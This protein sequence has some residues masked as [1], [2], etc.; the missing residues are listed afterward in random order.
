MSAESKWNSCCICTTGPRPGGIVAA[1]PAARN[2][3]S[4]APMEDAELIVHVGF[5]ED[6]AALLRNDQPTSTFT[7]QLPTSVKLLSIVPA[8]AEKR[9]SHSRQYSTEP[10]V[11][12]SAPGWIVVD[13]AE[14][15]WV[16]AAPAEPEV[17]TPDDSETCSA[18]PALLLVVSVTPQLPEATFSV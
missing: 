2:S 7:D 3:T 15:L 12:V 11:G 10:A 4:I 1:P 8:V 16:A 18:H 5:V 14:L 13:E 17:S 9:T 6:A